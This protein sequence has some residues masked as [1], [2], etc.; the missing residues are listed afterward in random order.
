[1]T[2]TLLLYTLWPSRQS[3]PNQSDFIFQ[4]ELKCFKNTRTSLHFGLVDKTF[5]AHYI[6]FIC[7]LVR[8][9]N[10]REMC[11]YWDRQE[12]PTY[13]MICKLCHASLFLIMETLAALT[14]KYIP[15]KKQRMHCIWWDMVG[16]AWGNGCRE[17]IL[18]KICMLWF[19]IFS[20]STELLIES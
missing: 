19:A 1:M 5:R 20:E 8:L 10:L 11:V 2:T 7:L 14:L 15:L 16:S 9:T 12:M 18:R 6:P 17:R 4:R 13:F 3:G